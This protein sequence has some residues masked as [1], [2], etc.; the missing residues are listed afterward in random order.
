MTLQTG[1]KI[2]AM[3][4]FPN[5]S[6]SKDNPTVNFGQLIEYNLR[7]ISLQKKKNEARS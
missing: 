6:R 5:I 1:K 7:N 2:T 4:M 3:H